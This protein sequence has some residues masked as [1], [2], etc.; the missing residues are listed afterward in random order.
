MAF[1]M[2]S[3]EKIRGE[4]WDYPAMLLRHTYNIAEKTVGCL[5]LQHSEVMVNLLNL[6]NAILCLDAMLNAEPVIPPKSLKIDQLDS[7]NLLDNEEYLI[8]LMGWLRAVC[9]SFDKYGIKPY[10]SV[11]EGLDDDL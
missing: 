5:S 2:V 10:I 11:E 4:T 3:P 9:V 6:Q 1:G 7:S 8:A